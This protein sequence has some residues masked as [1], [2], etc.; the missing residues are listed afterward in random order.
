MKG[1]LIVV[2]DAGPARVR[3]A[4]SSST[5]PAQTTGAIGAAKRG[6]ATHL[7]LT[8]LPL[9]FGPYLHQVIHCA[10]LLHVGRLAEG[11]A[12]GELEYD[13]AVEEDS[14][15]ARSFFSLF[16][17]WGALTEGRVATAARLT[18]E[19]AGAFREMAWPLWVRS[20]LM[21]RAHALDQLGLRNFDI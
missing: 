10:A 2:Q 19:S 5:L 18:G 3:L 9:P 14:V 1:E 8:G 20:A 15:E 16:L 6:L 21:I 7:H 11:R 12:L 17:G 4:S 13:K